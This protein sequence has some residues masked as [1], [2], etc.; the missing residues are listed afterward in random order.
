MKQLMTFV[1][2]D[3]SRTGRIA[4]ST[5]LT[6]DAGF[7]SMAF[8]AS[9]YE[10]E[11]ADWADIDCDHYPNEGLATIG[12]G[13]MV[14]KWKHIDYVAWCSK[15]LNAQPDPYQGLM[16]YDCNGRPN[17]PASVRAFQLRE[18][19]LRPLHPYES[20]ALEHPYESKALERLKSG[21]R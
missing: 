17:F 14:K 8:I 12:H 4:I 10:D 3:L 5:A 20:T 16:V 15:D 21:K 2:S 19:Q 13:A 9:S 18:R 11:V 6:F 7:E 1:D